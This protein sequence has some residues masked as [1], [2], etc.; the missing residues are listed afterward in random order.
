MTFYAHGAHCRWKMILDYFGE[1]DDFE[2]CGTCD[3]C[4]RPAAVPDDAKSESSP[5]RG[6]TPAPP[7]EKPL[8]PGERVTVRKLGRGL[9]ESVAGDRVH[10]S[11]ADGRTREFLRGYVQRA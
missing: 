6:D 7:K 2:R 3:N 8:K 4:R 5:Q 11:F 10:V 9:V 1:G